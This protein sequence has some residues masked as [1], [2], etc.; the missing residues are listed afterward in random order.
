MQLDVK[1]VELCRCTGYAVYR[2]EDLELCSHLDYGLEYP[3]YK[4]SRSNTQQESESKN[5][6]RTAVILF[7]MFLS[8]LFKIF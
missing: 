6:E 4:M 2:M 5:D 1:M 3:L 8:L 7:S